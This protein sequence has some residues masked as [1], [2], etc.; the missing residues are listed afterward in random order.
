[1]S[2]NHVRSSKDTR[3]K[4]AELRVQAIRLQLRSGFHFCATAENAAGLGDLQLGRNAVRN[5]R[6]VAEG[7]RAHLKE[8]H[9]V[10]AESLVSLRTELVKLQ[11]HLA[12]VEGR[13]RGGNK[14]HDPLK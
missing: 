1:M 13:L 9:H 12:A 8:P 11:A 2:A 5:A 7:V 10:P 6:K 3:S 14:R 4:A